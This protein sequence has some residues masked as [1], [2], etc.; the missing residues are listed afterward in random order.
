MAFAHLLVINVHSLTRQ[1]KDISLSSSLLLYQTRC[2][3]SPAGKIGL[4]S[5]TV[6]EFL[7]HVGETHAFESL[8]HGSSEEQPLL[9]LPSNMTKTD[10]FQDYVTN[11]S[12]LTAAV[13]KF[14][15]KIPQPL[16]LTF[17]TFT[18]Y[19]E[20]GPPTLKIFEKG[21]NFRDLCTTLQADIAGL[22]EH[23]ERHACFPNLL[24]T[25][26]HNANVEDKFYRSKRA[27]LKL[28]GISQPV[29]FDF[30]EIV[31]LARFLRQ[32]GQLYFVTSLK[33]NLFGV[34]DSKS[35]R[36]IVFGLPEGHWPCKKNANTIISIL[37]YTIYTNRTRNHVS[38]AIKTLHLHADSY[39]GQNKNQFIPLYLCWQTIF[40]VNEEVQ[41]N[42]MVAG[43]TKNF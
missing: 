4:H 6:H 1:A 3:E 17:S 22:Y 31:F 40:C 26:K 20:K 43:H 5:Q 7:R 24:S 35:G 37:R 2:S 36:N 11:Y 15:K 29:L 34:Y 10:I 39:A 27:Y 13:K 23:D 33:T 9:M 18:R 21:S 32:P 8:G 38:F 41:L 28:D 16:P 30:A 12:T 25:Q 19:W 42:F 14:T